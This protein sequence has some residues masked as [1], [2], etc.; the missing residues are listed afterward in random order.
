[1]AFIPIDEQAATL[2]AVAHL[3]IFNTNTPIFGDA[4]AHGRGAL[5]RRGEVV[6]AHLLR[7]RQTGD[8]AGGGLCL[9]GLGIEPVFHGMQGVEN[10][11]QRVLLRHGI[12]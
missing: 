10:Q 11:R 3:G 12:P 9:D 5:G 1:M 4:V 7:H 2:A 6:G 8:G